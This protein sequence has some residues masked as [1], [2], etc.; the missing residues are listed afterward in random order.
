MLIRVRVFT[1]KYCGLCEDVLE[2]LQSVSTRVSLSLS[3]SVPNGRSKC[4]L[5]LAPAQGSSGDGDTRH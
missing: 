2:Q 5:L 4:H 1:K 3:W